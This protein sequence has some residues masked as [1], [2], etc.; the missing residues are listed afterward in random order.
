MR[1]A[2]PLI[3]D[4]SKELRAF[5]VAVTSMVD[6]KRGTGR[7]SLIGSVLKDR[8]RTGKDTG[9]GRFPSRMFVINAAWLE[10]ALVAIDLL[11][12]THTPT[13]RRRPGR[14]RTQEAA[15]PAAARRGPPD[16]LRPPHLPAYCR[17]LALGRPS[18]RRVRP[19]RRAISTRYLTRRPAP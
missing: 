12:W 1:E 13:P 15:L 17:A 11:A 2:R 6:T 7:G 3:G 5:R 16:P 10:S 18:S 19:A 8:I 14:R 9:F 4:P